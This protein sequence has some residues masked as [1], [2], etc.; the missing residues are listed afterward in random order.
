MIDL[1]H[2]L[3]PGHGLAINGTHLYPPSMYRILRG[4]TSSPGS[5]LETVV[6]IRAA[7]LMIRLTLPS[8]LIILEIRTLGQY[9]NAVTRV[10]RCVPWTPAGTHVLIQD[11]AVVGGAPTI[12]NKLRPGVMA[13]RRQFTLNRWA[14][15]PS[16]SSQ[17]NR[18]R[19]L[20]GVVRPDSRV[21]K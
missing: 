7:K 19:L 13:S 18:L 14:P 21:R 3:L 11:V 6:L 15:R 20:G 8:V 4:L 1:F 16:I 9:C 2:A 17:L 10:R 12:D 5:R